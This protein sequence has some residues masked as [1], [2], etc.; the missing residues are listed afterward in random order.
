MPVETTERDIGTLVA[1][2]S[3][4]EI[5]LPEIQRGYIWKPT[6]VAK[7]IDSLYRRYPTGTLLFWRATED[8]A[9]RKF[10][11]GSYAAD[12]VIQ[13]LY[14]LDGQQRLTALHRVLSDHAEAQVVFNVE[15]QAFQ[16]QS[17]ATARDPRWIKVYDVIHQDA[18]HFGLTSRLREAVVGRLDHKE[19]GRRL[20][21]LAGVRDI[22]YHMEVLAEFPYE[23]VTQI[24]VRVN[25]G[26]RSLRTSDLALATLSAR[27]PGVLS[28]L[29]TEAAKWDNQGYGGL[30]VTFLT[31]A[32]A[33]AVLG[34]GLSVWSH[35]RLVAKTDDELEQGWLTVCRGLNHLIPLLKNNLKVSHSSL[36]PSL[37]VLLPLIVM[38]GERP[39]EPLDVE[40]ANGILY[41]LLVATIRNRY[42]GSTDTLLSQ[43][44]PAA[45]SED[46]VRSLLT[47]LGIVGTRVEV[48]PRDLAGRSVNSPYFMLS[49]L[50]AQKRQATDW[51][52][53]S[54]VAMGGQGGQK[55][56][57]HHIHPQATLR[58]HP[59]KFAKAE[60]NDLANLAFISGKANRKIADQSPTKY[61]PSLNPADLTAHL[62]PADE[63]LRD[64][65]AFR[66]FLL[67]RRLLL[68]AAMTELLDQYRPQWLG[69]AAT[70]DADPLAGSSV[71]FTI[72][73]S[74]WDASR[75]LIAATRDDVQWKGVLA[76]ADLEAVL[77]SAASGLDGDIK[78]GDQEVPVTLDGDDV[79]IPLGP[80]LIT[81]SVEEWRK[82]L[83]REREEGTLPLSQL[84]NPDSVP[85]QAD[86]AL[87]P[88]ANV[89]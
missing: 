58:G 5:K 3:Q 48:T 19:I 82:A 70:A 78:V 53:G 51:W 65:S 4:G 33:G 80:F 60:I 1:Q 85:W 7:L 34:R 20:Q 28:K 72:Y 16:N 77:E 59:A 18:D 88:M 73:E 54:A 32:L 89:E 37:I 47:N 43:D 87:F 86:L 50:V 56:E 26:G 42:S 29:E 45:R 76:L 52:F 83:E 84:P 55:L 74:R 81:G 30:D 8:P 2:V 57:Y 6:Q 17:A 66:E 25:S 68:A 41:W 14:L 49:F 24:F 35:A 64:S 46:P 69:Q 79:Q 21:R 31:R 15:T 22:R 62:V 61:F 11:T 12:P 63:E 10:A 71:D 13:P 9:T 75:M 39:D 36:L 67:A 27:W 23:E 38:L 40:I 44:I